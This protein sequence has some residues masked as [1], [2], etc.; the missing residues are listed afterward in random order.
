MEPEQRAILTQRQVVAKKW[1]TFF[2]WLTIS[3]YW[4]FALS[5]DSSTKNGVILL[6]G[7]LL[8]GF[9]LGYYFNLEVSL[10]IYLVHKTA[11]VYQG[12]E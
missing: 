2:L 4:S 3:L 1:S 8:L 6:I 12:Y 5:T 7:A 9:G 11:L 10:L